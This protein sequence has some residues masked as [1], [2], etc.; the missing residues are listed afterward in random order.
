MMLLCHN[1]LA[2]Q[3][4]ALKV[5][6]DEI[7]IGRGGHNQLILDS[8]LVA[9]NAAVLRR[10]A[11]GWLIQ[12]LGKNGC[13][14]GDQQIGPGREI[15]LSAKQNIEIFPFEISLEASAEEQ[16]RSV[17]PFDEASAE[18]LA[19]VH[20]RLLALMDVETDDA[21][22]RDNPEYQL[23]LEHMIEQ[24]A[25]EE[26]MAAEKH[27]GLVNYIAGQ[28]VRQTLIESLF[29][30]LQIAGAQTAS[31]TLHWSR[32][33]SAV[34]HRE[35][36]LEQIV[37][38]MQ[39]T[40]K[41]LELTDLSEQMD[42][43]DSQFESVWHSESQSQL[44]D[45]LLYLAM[46]HLKKQVKDI[47]FGYGP[48]EDLLRI[49]TISEI[50]VVD[51]DHI[52]IEKRGVV[53]DSG[54]RFI[55]D[56]VTL[57]VI[58]RIVS[59]VGRRID[60]SQ[61]LVDARL[62][63]GSR[64]NAII[65]PLAISGPCITIRKFPLNRMRADD[66]VS[67][68]AMSEAVREFL[69]ACVLSRRNILISG[70]TGTGKT[71]LL[72]CL[73]DFIPQKERIVTIE[74]TAELQISKE[75]V[76]RLEVKPANVEGAGAYSIHDLVKNALRMRP[77]RIIVGECRG[78]EALDMLQAMNTG[79]EGSLTTIHANTPRDVQLRLEVMVRTAADLPIES[80]H[81]QIASAIDLVVQLHRGRDGRR[82]VTQVTEVVGMDDTAG[83]VRM[84]DL[85]HLEEIQGEERLVP[86]GHLP[87]FI[88]QLMN[89]GY[90]LANFYG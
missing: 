46:R 90:D 51:R 32:L 30:P 5:S 71:T 67:C 28:S 68:G 42:R 60:K 57:S 10:D 39:R 6:G 88:D 62:L 37:E 52:F 27:A 18:L 8:P 38:A 83:G 33:V 63:D 12:A 59:K 21:E 72:N 48:L 85:F 79:H 82:R 2:G 41:V 55:S 89:Y 22:R 76:V 14:I 78:G 40:L 84:K 66:L 19:N 65:S 1:V 49:P 34:S 58:D 53:E 15:A 81:R 20:R 86:T 31:P 43:I 24:I 13:K 3:R 74:D 47:V 87:G 36:D 26:G 75:H 56:D 45:F 29:A 69:K 80:I 35:Q 16:G 70:G 50:M 11:N 77:D 54:R 64:V 61:P 7:T 9:F 4:S 73:T 17:H 25:I 23:N 44:A